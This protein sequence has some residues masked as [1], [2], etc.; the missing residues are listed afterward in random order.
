MR[1]IAK[2]GTV[3]RS[4]LVLLAL[5]LALMSPLGASAVPVAA[6]AAP[7]SSGHSAQHITAGIAADS[8]AAEKPADT[9]TPAGYG[10]A[11]AVR[12]LRAQLTAGVTASRAPPATV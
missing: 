6:G 5:L 7:A 1:K 8:A 10:T 9:R 2:R 12:A 3:L 4:F 11:H